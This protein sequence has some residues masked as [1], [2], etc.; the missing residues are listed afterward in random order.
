MKA[1]PFDYVAPKTV[2]EANT[3]LASAGLTHSGDRRR[4]ISSADAQSAGCH[5][6]FAR[7]PLGPRRTA[8]SYR[9]SHHDPHWRAYH[10]RR[11]RRRQ[12]ARPVRRADAESRLQISYRAVRNHGTVGGSVALADPAADWPGCLLA[13]SAQV[14]ICRAQGDA[15]PAD[16]PVPP[17]TVFDFARHRR[18]HRRVRHSPSRRDRSA[19]VSS[20]SRAKV[21]RSRTRSPL[22]RHAA[23][24]DRSRLCSPRPQRALMRSPPPPAESRPGTPQRSPYALQLPRKSR[25]SLAPM[26]PICCACIRRPSC[27]RCGRCRPNE[28][29]VP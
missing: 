28:V 15:V 8:G 20:R 1:A 9:D 10:P 14:R 4:S 3:S 6:R 26:I 22:R 24:A 16:Q 17:G 23:A 18:N 25:H 2:G 7:R 12:A 11:H 29:S 27:G 21:A 19:G 5:A 13:L